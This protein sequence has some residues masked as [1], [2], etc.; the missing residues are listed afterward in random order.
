MKCLKLP[1]GSHK[2]KLFLTPA[3]S[4]FGL[5]PK[6][7]PPQPAASSLAALLASLLIFETRG[8]EALQY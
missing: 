2:V 4:P 5:L 6:L 8:E 1:T 7:H 3:Q